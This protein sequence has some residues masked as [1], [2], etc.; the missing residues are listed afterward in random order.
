MTCRR[1]RY[2]QGKYYEIIWLTYEHSSGGFCRLPTFYFGFR[3]VKGYIISDLRKEGL[4]KNQG[5][6]LALDEALIP[7]KHLSTDI[8]IKLRTK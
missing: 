4:E 3:T 8:Y 1:T 7:F 2:I 6:G 5:S